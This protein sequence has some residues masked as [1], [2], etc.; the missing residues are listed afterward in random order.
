MEV[1]TL[2]VQKLHVS[3]SSVILWLIV[4]FTLMAQQT[5]KTLIQ[6]N[7]SKTPALNSSKTSA[8]KIVHTKHAEVLIARAL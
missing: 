6:E 5:S 3:L 8:S 1:K 7:G 4:P 2:T